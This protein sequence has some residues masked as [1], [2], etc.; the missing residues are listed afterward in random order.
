MAER[1]SVLVVDDQSAFRSVAGQDAVALAA[2]LQPDVVVMDINLP[3]ISGLQA[4]ARIVAVRPATRVVLAST[5]AER[6]LPTA[7][8]TCG[9]VGYVRK[10]D[11][12]PDSLRTAAEGDWM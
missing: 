11:L 6:D 9:A 3:G 1:V 12:S 8:R 4:T 7:S 10:E 2:A 5:Y